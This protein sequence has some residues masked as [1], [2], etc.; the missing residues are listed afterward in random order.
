VKEEDR[1]PS[2]SSS[3]LRGLKVALI[4]CLL[5]L[6]FWTWQQS[7]EPPPPVAPDNL[8]DVVGVRLLYRYEC[9]RCHQI[10][11]PGMNGKMGPALRGLSRHSRAYL[12]ESLREPG[13]VVVRGYINGMPSYAHLS[14]TEV[15]EL[16]D[17]LVTL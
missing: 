13:K 5:G 8:K 11:L 1:G 7:Q 9:G 2:R 16:I 17:Y 14:D 4:W 10:N 12:E 3:F 15:R 6:G